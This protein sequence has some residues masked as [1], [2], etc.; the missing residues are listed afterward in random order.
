MLLENEADNDCPGRTP[1]HIAARKGLL[2][3]IRLLVK[4]SRSMW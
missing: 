4:V 2:P 3:T 1:L